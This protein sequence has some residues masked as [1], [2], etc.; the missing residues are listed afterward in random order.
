MQRRSF[1]KTM[2]WM[3]FAFGS[4][5]LVTSAASCYDANSPNLPPCDPKHPD[6]SAGCWDRKAIEA[7]KDVANEG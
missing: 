2:A 6:N 5:T 3:G 7:G 1:L 4:G